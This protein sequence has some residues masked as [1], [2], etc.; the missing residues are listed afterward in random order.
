MQ[1]LAGTR[2]WGLSGC[3]QIWHGF[4]FLQFWGRRKRKQR[5]APLEGWPA[6]NKASRFE[7][8]LFFQV[9]SPLCAQFNACELQTTAQAVLGGLFGTKRQENKAKQEGP[10]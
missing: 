2:A 7:I 1:Q 8:T 10:V 3:S 4:Q 5:L 6:V 9:S